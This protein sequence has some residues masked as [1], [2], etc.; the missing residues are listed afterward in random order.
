LSFWLLLLLLLRPLL[1]QPPFGTSRQ[2]LIVVGN[3]KHLTL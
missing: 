1:L 3:P 2:F